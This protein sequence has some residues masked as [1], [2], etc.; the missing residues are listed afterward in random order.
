MAVIEVF[1][2]IHAVRIVR[3]KGIRACGLLS[4]FPIAYL[5]PLT[6]TECRYSLGVILTA[7]RNTLEK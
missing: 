1:H 5:K 6:C 2:I 7:L 4:S 3:P